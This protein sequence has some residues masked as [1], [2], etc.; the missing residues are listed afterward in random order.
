MNIDNYWLDDARLD[1]I[2]REIPSTAWGRELMTTAWPKRYPGLLSS[3]TYRGCAIVLSALNASIRSTMQLSEIGRIIENLGHS[4]KT[5]RNYPAGSDRCGGAV[6][7]VTNAW[8]GAHGGIS[9]TQIT[10]ALESELIYA[11]RMFGA[12]RKQESAGNKLP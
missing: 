4:I 3:E 5:S 12:A 1:D 6:M 11:A 2:R 10:E 7:T 9:V 8:E